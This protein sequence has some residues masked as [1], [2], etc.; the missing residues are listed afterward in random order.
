MDIPGFSPIRRVE[1]HE[2]GCF[3]V[4]VKPPDFMELPEVS[5]VLT[6]D[7]YKRYLKW[8][9]GTLIQEALPELTADEREMLMSGI[10]DADFYWLSRDA[11]ET[12]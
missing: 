5:V 10:G 6:S 2:D 4:Y 12:T 9:N 7:Q 1:E 3:T 8:R 11:D